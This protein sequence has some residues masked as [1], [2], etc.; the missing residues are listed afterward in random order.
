MSTYN[1]PLEDMFFALT[2]IANIDNLSKISG[3]TDISSDNVK[4]LIEEASKIC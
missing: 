1:A 3:N 2:E 4:L